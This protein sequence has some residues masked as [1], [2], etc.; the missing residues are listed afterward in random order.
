M[1]RVHIVL[2]SVPRC[3]GWI[4]F[5]RDENV[6]KGCRDDARLF[7]GC[8]CTY[9]GVGPSSIQVFIMVMPLCSFYSN[10][11]VLDAGKTHQHR[12]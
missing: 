11:L 7:S 6:C 1:L 12:F 8:G 10:M 9:C 3:N 5:I 2:S 4:V